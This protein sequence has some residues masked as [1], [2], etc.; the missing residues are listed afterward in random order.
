[1]E[2][3]GRK[4]RHSSHGSS[5]VPEISQGQPGTVMAFRARRRRFPETWIV[6]PSEFARDCTKY[7]GSWREF[8]RISEICSRGGRRRV[9]RDCY[10]PGR[11]PGLRLGPRP[12][13]GRLQPTPGVTCRWSRTRSKSRSRPKSRSTSSIGS[14]HSPRSPLRARD[15]LQGFLRSS[16]SRLAAAARTFSM[17]SLAAIPARSA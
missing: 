3:P 7:R 6:A 10:R 16:S 8:Q 1:M 9:S 4:V 11:G 2:T 12:G 5:R 14:A 17:R 15:G 13:P